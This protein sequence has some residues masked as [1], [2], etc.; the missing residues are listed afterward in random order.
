MF[1]VVRHC[2]FGNKCRR[3]EKSDICFFQITRDLS[4]GCRRAAPAIYVKENKTVLVMRALLSNSSRSSTAIEKG[5]DQ[6]HGHEGEHSI[7]SVFEGF[8]HL[9]FLHYCTLTA[10]SCKSLT[11]N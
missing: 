7:R 10:L 1:L 8:Q 6:G 11:I 9:Q 4:R 5:R 3:S 2:V